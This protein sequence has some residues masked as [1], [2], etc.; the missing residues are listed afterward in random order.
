[1]HTWSGLTPDEWLDE[2]AVLAVRMS[3]D[4][5]SA[6]LEEPEES[7][8]AA[9]IRE[10]EERIL[11]S[12]ADFLTTAIEHV[13]SGRLAGYTR[14]LVPDSGGPVNQW[15]TIVRREDRGHRL[16]MLLKI[17]NLQELDAR[18]PGHP[19]VVTWNAEENRHMLDV[20]EAIGF[21]P[22]GYEGAWRKDLGGETDG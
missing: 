14:F 20:N 11:E 18:F 5:P 4:A 21:D 1:V 17:A 16:G 22:I 19:S 12:P 10:R 9:R 7:W 6:G 13:G 8:D 15:T 3:T 2:M